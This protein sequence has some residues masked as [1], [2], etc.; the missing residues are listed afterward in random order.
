MCDHNKI[1]GDHCDKSSE[2][3]KGVVC[4]YGHCQNP[5]KIYKYKNGIRDTFSINHKQSQSGLT[6]TIALVV[7]ACIICVF[8]LIKKIIQNK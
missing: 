2:C 8:L 1:I 4:K 6:T 5:D 7:L 3:L